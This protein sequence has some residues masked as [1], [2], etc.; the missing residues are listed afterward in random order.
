MDIVG[1]AGEQNIQGEDQQK[2]DVYET[3]FLFKR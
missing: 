1:A 2:L 3:K